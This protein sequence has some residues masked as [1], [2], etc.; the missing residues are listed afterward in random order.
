MVAYIP[1]TTLLPTKTGPKLSEHVSELSANS[2]PTYKESDTA[3]QMKLMEEQL[4][5]PDEA[6]VQIITAPVCFWTGDPAGPSTN[7]YTT[8]FG[9]HH[10]GMGFYLTRPLS[11]GSVHIKS[12][13]ATTAPSI[14]PAYLEHPLDLEVLARMLLHVQYRIGA[15]EPLASK[16]KKGPDGRAVP[17]K[18]MKYAE[19]IEQARELVREWVYT[20]YHPIGT[21]SML[22]QEKGGVVGTD[23]KVYGVG[24]LRVCDASVFPTHVQ[25]CFDALLM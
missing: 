22:P 18:G 13:D 15:T 7:V 19:D 14:D 23:L 6:A 24:N 20:E 3:A 10:V 25:V 11:R 2:S 12:S 16:F 8:D 1:Y 17:L 9:G 21:C 4:L 5:R